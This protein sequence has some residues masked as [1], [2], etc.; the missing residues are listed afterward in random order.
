MIEKGYIEICNIE[1]MEVMMYMLHVPKGKSDVCMVYDGSKSGLNEALW[2]PW[3]AL[4]TVDSVAWWVVVGSWLANNDYRKQFL[5]FPLHPDLQRYC[6]A[7]LTQL[8][9]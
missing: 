5:N 4:P 7:D 9:L 8:F 2:A 1:L 3:F 6:G